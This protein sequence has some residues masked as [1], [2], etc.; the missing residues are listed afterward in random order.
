Y[1]VLSGSVQVLRTEP[2]GSIVQLVRLQAGQSFGEFG[3]VEG[4]PRAASAV[5]DGELRVLTI[6]S[7]DFRR[8]HG[9]D[10]Q[11][12]GHAA[13]LRSMYSYGGSSFAVQ[14]TAE[15]FGRAAVGTL[16]RLDGGR[17]VVAHRVIGQDTWS[18]QQADTP[19]DAVERRFADA[20]QGIERTLLISGNM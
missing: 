16:Y 1:V 18:L 10:P 5:A 15:L 12:R 11:G 8:A 9:N 4:K 14:F 2:D 19:S 20:A 17:T 13:A 6:G 7:E 3:L